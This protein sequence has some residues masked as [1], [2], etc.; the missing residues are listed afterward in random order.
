MKSGIFIDTG[1]GFKCFEPVALQDIEGKIEI[2]P[3]YRLLE[4]ANMAL[5]ELRA[6]EPV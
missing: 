1:K 4:R 5:G 6:L 3:L 2:V